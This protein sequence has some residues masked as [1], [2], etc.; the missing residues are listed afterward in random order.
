VDSDAEENEVTPMIDSLRGK[1][2]RRNDT[3]VTVF[4]PCERL[5]LGG[6]D[7]SRIS[8]LVDFREWQCLPTVVVTKFLNN[9]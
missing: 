2:G 9:N 1:S 7:F 8:L 5:E 6:L 3:Y 4:G